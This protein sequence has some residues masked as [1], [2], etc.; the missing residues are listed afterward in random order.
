MAR[1]SCFK[2]NER[3]RINK[4]CSPGLCRPIE[5]ICRL[6]TG[7]T[8]I[9]HPPTIKMGGWTLHSLLTRCIHLYSSATSCHTD[10]EL[11]Q[12]LMQ[13]AYTIA[14][15]Y[16]AQTVGQTQR[17]YVLSTWLAEAG[18]PYGWPFFFPRATSCPKKTRIKACALGTS[19]WSEE[20]RAKRL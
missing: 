16:A 10:R 20:D 8:R 11:R 1:G 5:N 3:L 19:D 14:S 4:R 6:H 17:N 12:S 7:F 2:W 15:F 9:W 18:T 13:R